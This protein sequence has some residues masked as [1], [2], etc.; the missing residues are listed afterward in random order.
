MNISGFWVS[1]WEHAYGVPLIERTENVNVY[2]L[3]T[4]ARRTIPHRDVSAGGGGGEGG[5]RLIYMCSSGIGR[6]DV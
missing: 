2:A 5:G 4:Q 1:V 6:A 3:Q